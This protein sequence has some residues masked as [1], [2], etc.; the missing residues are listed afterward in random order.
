MADSAQGTTITF[1]TSSYS[2]QV[3]SVSRTGN[4]RTALKT[5]HLGTTGAHTYIPS[6]L[7]EEGQLDVEII[8]DPDLP[9]PLSAVAET[10]TL[11][12]PVP[13]GLT[14]GATHSGTGFLIEKNYE[15]PLDDLMVGGYTIQWGDDVTQA[16]AS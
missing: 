13:S 1:G 10:I 16:D 3:T 5:S 4:T 7:I 6:D 9:P 2:A 14:N 8:Y 15:L 12:F 11:T